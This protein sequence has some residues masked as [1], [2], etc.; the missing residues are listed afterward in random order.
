MIIEA[1]H[2]KPSSHELFPNRQALLVKRQVTRKLPNGSLSPPRHRADLI[3]WKPTTSSALQPMF[4]FPLR[5]IHDAK[6]KLVSRGPLL[7]L[8]SITL[9][10]K[11]SHLT[12][13]SLRTETRF[14]SVHG[15][16]SQVHM[17]QAAVDDKTKADIQEI[18]RYSSPIVPNTNSG[19]P[20]AQSQ[21]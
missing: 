21:T 12:P 5:W 4:D 10:L 20:K 3:I 13:G 9:Q 8:F 19:R 7:G 6:K 14:Q 2:Y 17:L 15:S 16:L 1:E 18:C 11:G